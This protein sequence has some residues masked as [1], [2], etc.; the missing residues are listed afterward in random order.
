MSVAVSSSPL[1][2][3]PL[4]LTLLTSCVCCTLVLSSRSTV[5]CTILRLSFN[6]PANAASGSSSSLFIWAATPWCCLA[7]ASTSPRTVSSDVFRVPISCD[8]SDLRDSDKS[9]RAYSSSMD[10]RAVFPETRSAMRASQ[11]VLGMRAMAHRCRMS[12]VRRT[13]ASHSACA[14]GAA[15]HRHRPFPRSC[16]RLSHVSYTE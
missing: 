5:F 3:R 9:F 2:Q 4:A 7:M 15:I 6:A 11:A 1:V 12:E 14:P 16:W 10:A 8:P 13:S